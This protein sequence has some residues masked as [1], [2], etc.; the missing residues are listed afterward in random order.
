MARRGGNVTCPHCGKKGLYKL[1]PHYPDYC[2]VALAARTATAPAAARPAPPRRAVAQPLP[3]PPAAAAL[4]ALT[5]AQ[6]DLV[7]QNQGLVGRVAKAFGWTGLPQQERFDAGMLGLVQAAQAY[8]PARGASFSTAAY[9]WIEG[10]IQ[11]TFRQFGG[12]VRVSSGKKA[13]LIRSRLRDAI[14]PDLAALAAELKVERRYVEAVYARMGTRGDRV[15]DERLQLADEG[16]EAADEQ[17]GRGAQVDKLRAAVGR[18]PSYRDQQI[19]KLRF[20]GDK[21]MPRAAIGRRMHLTG[22]R[23]R[24]LEKL[25]LEKLKRFTHNE[26]DKE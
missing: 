21:K 18:L 23:V 24:Q 2:P 4:P 14:S 16:A 12:P 6:Q 9:P 7:L 1:S 20:L 8:D 13:Q 22:E 15:I 10:A 19:V 5:R 17:L 3:P 11:E 25:A 26:D